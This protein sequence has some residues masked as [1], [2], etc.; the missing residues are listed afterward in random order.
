MKIPQ[1]GTALYRE[2]V[3][4]QGRLRGRLSLVPLPGAPRLVGGADV[5]CQLRGRTFWGG[6]V[7]CE[8]LEGF[9]VV[10]SAVARME[11]DFPYI[12]G[13]LAFREVPVLSAAY[14][15]LSVK[16]AVTLVDAQGTAHPRRFGAAAHLGVVLNVPTVG[17]AKSLLCGECGKL[18]PER[19]ASSPIVHENETVGLALRIRTGVK[20]VYVSPGHRSD[21]E[22]AAALVLACAPRFRIPEPIRLAHKLV[23]EAR[24]RDG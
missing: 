21:L 22:T 6:W 4:E 19:G 3:S 11:V 10:C 7:V 9:R 17:C 24:R 8:A 18:G 15:E 23:N 16:P 14:A 12:P 2:A 5:S 1:Y 20:P 13:L